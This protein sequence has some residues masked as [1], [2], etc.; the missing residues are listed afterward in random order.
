VVT[1]RWWAIG[2]IFAVILVMGV[3]GYFWGTC[4]AKNRTRPGR[5]QSVAKG[6]LMRCG[7]NRHL[8]S[9]HDLYG[10]IVLMAGG[11]GIMALAGAART[12]T[13]LPVIDVLI[14]GVLQSG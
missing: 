2:L 6:P 10:L 9:I 11:L 3:V 8:A 7:S 13:G 14:K 1:L 12:A 4:G 5:C